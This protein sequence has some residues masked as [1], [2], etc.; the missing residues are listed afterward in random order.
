MIEIDI[1]YCEK[2][3][4]K[5]EFDR[6]SKIILSFKQNVKITGNSSPPRTGSFEVL[7]NNKIIFSKLKLGDFPKA[8]EIYSWFN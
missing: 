6:V 2:W 7:F 4:Y 1:E 3:N 5:P 8:S